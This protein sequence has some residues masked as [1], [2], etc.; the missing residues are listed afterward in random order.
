MFQHV[1]T[2]GYVMTLKPFETQRSKR[3]RSRTI[4]SRLLHIPRYQF[5]VQDRI[6]NPVTA[7]RASAGICECGAR[8]K[9]QGMLV[10]LIYIN[11]HDTIRREHALEQTRTDAIATVP[12]IDEQRLQLTVGRTGKAD[13]RS[14]AFRDR[15]RHAWQILCCE[16]PLNRAPILRSKETIRGVDRGTPHLHELGILPCAFHRAKHEVVNHGT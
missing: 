4:P 14:V 2:K 7:Q 3:V 10:L 12:S 8:V 6:R 16:S 13:R 1:G 9:V 11:S 5:H 15:Q